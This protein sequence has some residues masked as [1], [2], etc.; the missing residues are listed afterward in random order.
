MFATNNVMTGTVVYKS[1]SPGGLIDFTGVNKRSVSFDANKGWNWG[2][3]IWGTQV[4]ANDDLLPFLIESP[5][6][7]FDDHF[8]AAFSTP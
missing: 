8:L 2:D 6:V 7:I 4:K 3:A 1:Y 5:S